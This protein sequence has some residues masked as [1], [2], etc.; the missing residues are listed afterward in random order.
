M[1]Y[2]RAKCM[3]IRTQTVLLRSR[4][5]RER[6]GVVHNTQERRRAF[7]K[8]LLVKTAIAALAATGV[9]SFVGASASAAPRTH[10]N[11]HMELVLTGVQFAQNAALGMNTAAKAAGDTSIT[12]TGPPSINPVLA[13]Q[14]VTQAVSQSPDGIGIDPFT[15]DLWQ[16]TLQ[17]VSGQ[18]KNVLLMNDKPVISP[19]QVSSAAVKTY[20]GISDANYARALATATIAGAGLKPSTTGTV[21]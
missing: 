11:I 12:I 20:V 17:T 13:Q 7:S 18:V 2:A 1:R 15:P 9:A 10:V 3:Q 6:K 21:L 4:P 19:S 16:H 14:Q 5:L 8:R